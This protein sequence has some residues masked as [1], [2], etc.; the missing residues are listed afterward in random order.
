MEWTLVLGRFYGMDTFVEFL[1]ILVS[2]FISFYSFRV[3][4]MIK[5]KHY[6]WFSF[7]FLLLGISFIFKIFSNITFL[8]KVE[9]QE[10]NFVFTFMSHLEFAQLINFFSFILYKTSHLIGF[11]ILFLILTKN[12]DKERN[13]LFFY[14]SLIVILFS[15]Y[16]NFIFH[17]TVFFILIYLT[18]HFYENYKKIDNIN[19]FLVFISFLII[20]TSHLFFIFSDVYGLFYLFGEILLLIGFLCLLANQIGLKKKSKKLN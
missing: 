8:H 6:K 11:L 10:A 20:L 12:E 15:I 16:F 2:F 19:S 3:Y 18:L 4:K 14:L 13:L 1:T 5:D 7:A 9:V 17:L